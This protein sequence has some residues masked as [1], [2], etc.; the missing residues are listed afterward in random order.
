MCA[1]WLGGGSSRIEIH[2]VCMTNRMTTMVLLLHV[3]GHFVRIG[4]SMVGFRVLRC[5]DSLADDTAFTI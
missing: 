3:N 2:D 4:T 1:G 5:V